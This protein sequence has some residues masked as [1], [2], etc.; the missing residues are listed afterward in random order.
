MHNFLCD[1]DHLS[2][3]HAVYFFTERWVKLRDKLACIAHLA[4]MSQFKNVRVQFEPILVENKTILIIIFVCF[5]PEYLPICK[6]LESLIIDSTY[7]E[8]AGINQML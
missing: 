5:I 4:K 1:G 3:L 6:A 2:L 7:L 8:A